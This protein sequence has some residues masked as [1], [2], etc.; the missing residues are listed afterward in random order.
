MSWPKPGKFG[1][2]ENPL[3]QSPFDSG[4]SGDD[5]FVHNE[6]LLMDGEFFLLMDG[7][8]LLLMGT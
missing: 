7:T 8:H 4:N 5:I 2:V 3:V 6:F 1:I